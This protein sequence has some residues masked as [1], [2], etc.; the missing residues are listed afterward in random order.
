MFNLI[1]SRIVTAL[2]FITFLYLGLCF[3]LFC[4]GVVGLPDLLAWIWVILSIPSKLMAAGL[5]G[6]K[7]LG[8]LKKRA[9]EGIYK[10]TLEVSPWVNE[11]DYGF[12]ANC[13]RFA[14]NQW[15]KRTN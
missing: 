5:Y 3:A 12:F 9:E 1:I 7:L 4:T 13:V 6:A 14:R 8:F 11:K 2:I 10:G 15:A